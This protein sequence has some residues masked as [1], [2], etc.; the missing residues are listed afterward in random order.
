MLKTTLQLSTYQKKDAWMSIKEII[1]AWNENRK[2][3]GLA[4]WLGG[5][6]DDDEDDDVVKSTSYEV[7]HFACSLLQP[8]ATILPLGSKFSLQSLFSNILNVC[9]SLNV[10]YQVTCLYKTTGKIKVV[11]I[12]IFKFLVRRWEDKRLWTERKQQAFPESNLLLI[13]AWIRLWFVTVIPKYL[14]SDTF[15]KDLL[16]IIKL[17]FYCAFW[18]WDTLIYLV[19][20]VFTSRRTSVL[21][22]NWCTIFLSWFK[23]TCNW[24]SVPLYSN[25]FSSI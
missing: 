11:Y 1:Q 19:F 8:P 9:P 21:A 4:L 20:S 2:S 12:L 23:S 3:A 15:S 22:S 5:G 25:F 17:H 14:N 6:G 16:A 7:H 13:S 18:W 24:C 10:N